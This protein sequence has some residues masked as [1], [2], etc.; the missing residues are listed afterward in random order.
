M[1][2]Q[3]AC[4]F[5]Q[6]SMNDPKYVFVRCVGNK[7]LGQ[8]APFGSFLHPFFIPIAQK[9]TSLTGVNNLLRCEDYSQRVARK[10]KTFPRQILQNLSFSNRFELL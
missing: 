2:K 9:I 1:T 10:L 5:I 7:F 6:N 8:M 3:F 4:N